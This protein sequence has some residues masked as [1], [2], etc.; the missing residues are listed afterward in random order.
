M[1]RPKS[2][3]HAHL[4]KYV[5]VI[6]GSYWY[7][8]PSPD[9]GGIT[10]K[11]VRLGKFPEEEQKVWD[12]F[13]VVNSQAPL[14]T[15]HA[16]FEKYK[17]ECMGNLSPRTKKDYYRHLIALD[18]LF[19]H[20]HPNTV[21]PRNVG[22]MLS[23]PGRG[24]VQLN[25]QAAVLSAVFRK[26]VGRWYCADMN[27]CTGVQR[28]E[29]VP[30]QRY[31]MDDEFAALYSMATNRIQILMDMALLT[32]QRQHDLLT[33]REPAISPQGIYF[34]QGKRG[35]KVRVKWSQALVDVL[36]RARALGPDHQ[37]GYVLVSRLGT[38]YTTHGV[39]AIW[40]RLQV[41]AFEQGV[42]S[43]RFTFH[44]IRAKTVSDSSSLED[45]HIRAAHSDPKT[46][47]KIYDRGIR[48]V[49]PLR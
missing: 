30:R 39:S 36:A 38:P 22:M 8:P 31:I 44:D 25:Q 3:A 42:I 34:R 45:A 43:E 9:K 5:A 4:P 18:E 40:Q 6:H 1:A 28:N 13:K 11:P 10:P 32:G 20:Y 49:V 17:A 26:C 19:G 23:T 7:R 2:K 29:T 35:K 15:L 37:G 12:H 46:T 21:K 27:P 14:S 33:L 16:C 48:E 41:K 24:K 47:R